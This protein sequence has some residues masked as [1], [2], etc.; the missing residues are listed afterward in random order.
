VAASIDATGQRNKAFG[1]I[2]KKTD[3]EITPVSPSTLFP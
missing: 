1:I 3:K 2:V